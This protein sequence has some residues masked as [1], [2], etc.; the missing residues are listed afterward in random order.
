MTKNILFVVTLVI[1]LQSFAQNDTVFNTTDAKGLKQG[2][3][4]ATYENGKPKYYGF[5][6]DGK[7]LGYM[8]RYYDDGVI[9]AIVFFYPDFTTSFAKMYYQNGVLAGE[10]KYIGSVKDS[11][12]RYY[13]YYDKVLSMEESF[14][15]GK[16][17]GLTRKYYPNGKAA[18][19]LFWV[20]DYKHGS[21]KQYLPD[22]SIKLEATYN[23][24]L[25]VGLFKVYYPGGKVENEGQFVNNKME[26]DWKYYDMDGN[27]KMT[28]KYVNGV[29][30]NTDV[31]DKQ[32]AEYFKN[33]DKNKG[34]I[35]EPDENSMA[36]MPK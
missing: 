34:T 4:K 27:L 30:Q 17:D 23:K 11:I 28:I 35:P 25:R 26:G 32:E 3:W 1:G 16:K 2:W 14:K 15:M 22:G 36:P 6:K 20:N 7:P 13:S 5:F 9:K 24:D 10:G 12:W 31:L 8:K 18:E 21:W 33:L 29:A 19:E